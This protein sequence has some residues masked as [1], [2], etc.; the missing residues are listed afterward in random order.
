MINVTRIKGMVLVVDDI[1]GFLKEGILADEENMV[2]VS[3]TKKLLRRKIP[4]GWEV[5]FLCDSHRKGD[6]ELQIFDDHCMAGT[7]EAK[8]VDE[9]FEFVTPKN[10][11]PK[12]GHDGFYGTDLEEI[13]KQKN[14]EKVIV[15]GVCTDICVL[16][17]II[18]LRNIKLRNPDYQV[19]VP[20]DCVRAFD[21]ANTDVWLTH[22]EN[23]LD[24]Q[25]VEK[26]EEI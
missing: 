6:P 14:P 16:Y 7:E 19:I 15:V 21:V 17:T 2:V 22:M 20:K 3:E 4:V 12:P 11:I 5:L 18:G 25:V 13:L 8:V 1:N 23:V 10:Y 24:V 9:L 26:Q